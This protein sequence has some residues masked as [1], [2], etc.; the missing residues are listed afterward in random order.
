MFLFQLTKVPLRVP[1]L[2]ASARGRQQTGPPPPPGPAK[3]CKF[4]QRPSED[5]GEI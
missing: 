3:D 2:D 1:E 4:S 5:R